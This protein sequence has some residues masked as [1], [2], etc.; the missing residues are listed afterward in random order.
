MKVSNWLLGTNPQ[1]WIRNKFRIKC[2]STGKGSN[3]ENS[4][5]IKES[6]VN[7]VIHIKTKEMYE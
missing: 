2:R 3:N 1:F 4:G 6:N 5:T 7:R